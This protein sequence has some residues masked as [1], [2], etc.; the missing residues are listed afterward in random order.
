LEENEES[1]LKHEMDAPDELVWSMEV[2]DGEDDVNDTLPQQTQKKM[3][4]GVKK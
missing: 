1:D 3:R 2:G 4:S